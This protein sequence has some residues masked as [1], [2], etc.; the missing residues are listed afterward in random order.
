MT[1]TFGLTTV[2]DLFSKLERDADA[3]DDEVT[4][5]RLF[6]FVVTS[7]SLIDWIKNDP[8]VPASAKASSA[9][10]GLYGDKWLKICGDLATASKHFTLTTRVPVTAAATT[11]QGFGVGRYGKGGYGVGEEGIEVHLNDGT[12]L[13]CLD[14]AQGVITSWRAFFTIHGI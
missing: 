7:Y 2:R 3:L 12:T 9:I 5:D 1:L 6:N 10:H 8:L 4:S 13:P 11:A 14:L